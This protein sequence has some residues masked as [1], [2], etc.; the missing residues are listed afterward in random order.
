MAM[1]RDLKMATLLAITLIAGGV[2]WLSWTHRHSV[3]PARPT[4]VVAGDLSMRL[5]KVR[6]HGISG[7]KVLWE[8][9]AENFDFAKNRPLLR[10]SGLKKVSLLNEG[11]IDLTLSADALERNT[12]TG[13]ITISGNVTVLGNG[14]A[15]RAPFAA[16]DP[17]RELLQF[18]RNFT[19]QFGD[20]TL[21]SMGNTVYD[22]K[23]GIFRSN[24]GVLLTAKGNTLR[25]GSIE[26]EMATQN[27]H[28]YEPVAAELDIAN[29][30]AWMSGDPLLRI[31]EIPA[32]IRQRYHA[33]RT[34]TG[35]T[36]AVV[37][38]ARTPRG[39]PFPPARGAHP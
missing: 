19:A 6:L 30:D 35:S 33:Y 7:G 34:K 26:V 22:V 39:T 36:P 18:P 15:V 17:R 14:L 4:P 24:G 29:L 21:S 11:K 5:G 38:P 16:W 13:E 3:A 28:L 23:A 2:W 37:P 10:V 12:Y 31:P 9:E 8:I 1:T 25:A 27:F 20:Y 32:S